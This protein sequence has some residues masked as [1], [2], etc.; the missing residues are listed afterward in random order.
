VYQK[1]SYNKLKKLMEKIKED[2]DLS[3]TL[4]KHSYFKICGIV[5]L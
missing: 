4:K 1:Y 5:K 2:E 3:A